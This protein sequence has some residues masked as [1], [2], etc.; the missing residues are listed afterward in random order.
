[1][2]MTTHREKSMNSDPNLSDHPLS[3]WD[4]CV[5]VKDR[6]INTLL[7]GPAEIGQAGVL[8][9]SRAGCCHNKRKQAGSRLT[10]QHK[11]VPL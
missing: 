2:R 1:M 11:K 5:C 10:P 9:P 8:W 6:Y 3:C 7:Y 4:V